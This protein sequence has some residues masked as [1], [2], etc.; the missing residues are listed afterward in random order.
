V[1][2]SS[3]FNAFNYTVAIR[4]TFTCSKHG[5]ISC[6]LIIIKSKVF[7]VVHDCSALPLLCASTELNASIRLHGMYLR[8]AFRR[9][10]FRSVIQTVCR[11]LKLNGYATAACQSLK[12]HLIS[13]RI[14]NTF[15]RQ[16]QTN[17]IQAGKSRSVQYVK[18]ASR[19]VS[20]RVYR[21]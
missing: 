19:I 10:D 12:W 15:E 5:C 1:N 14:V 7:V 9:P 3:L 17:S 13:Y 8:F 16:V 2:I 21:F 18:I 6:A 4:G 20:Y 11:Q